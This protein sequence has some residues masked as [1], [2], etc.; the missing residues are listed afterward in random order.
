[1][2]WRHNTAQ[3]PTVEGSAGPDTGW[4]TT[5]LSTGAMA[6]WTAVMRWSAWGLLLTGPLLGG[7][8]LA[9]AARPAAVPTQA[10]APRIQPTSSDAVAP[11]GFAELYV[12]AYVKAGQR[13]A[14]V[15]ELAAFYPAARSMSWSAEGGAERTESASAVQVRQ[16]SAGY[17]SVTVAA[18]I[19]S[20]D[21]A[22]QLH[23]FQ[24]PV[25]STASTKGTASGWVAAALP[26]EVAAP[27]GDAA[28]A[29]E[30]SYGSGHAPLASDPAV[31]TIQGFLAAYL[32]GQG[33]VERYLSPGT[34]LHPVRPA[35][36]AAV[37][38]TQIADHGPGPAEGAEAQTPPDGVQRRLL[39][40]VEGDSR[41]ATGRPMTYAIELRARGGRWEIAA[42]EAA[43]ALA[44][45]DN[46]SH[47]QKGQG[48]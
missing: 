34:T 24:V 45:S 39:V 11:A 14:A 3:A 21:D 43:P 5:S 2:K 31:Q 13:D 20:K 35:P 12:A 17:W 6:N 32:T 42:L 23:Y 41:K 46:S 28:K 22:G 29:P 1:M 47:S 30:L 44:T 8:A 37:T 27:T 9:S 18:R 7:W 36:Y 16:I 15:Q 38:L 4:A 40:D 33:D 26:A 48:S 25:R 19:T 10:E